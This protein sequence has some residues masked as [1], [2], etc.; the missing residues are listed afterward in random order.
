MAPQS[1]FRSERLTEE[2]R[3]RWD[4]ED[5]AEYRAIRN[6]ENYTSPEKPAAT[7]APVIIHNHYQPPASALAPAPTRRPKAHS[8]ASFA[9][10]TGGK[11]KP[12]IGPAVSAD[13]I[14]TP[15][16]DHP[17]ETVQ[18]PPGR[19]PIPDLVETIIAGEGELRSTN[20]RQMA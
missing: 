3:Q 16:P 19:T 15:A 17:E 6:G 9:P 12:A 13:S 20:P 18:A 8:P 7:A 10:E 1:R 11:T 5:I 14:P 4:A 2:R